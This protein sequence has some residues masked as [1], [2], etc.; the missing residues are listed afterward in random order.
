MCGVPTSLCE[1]KKFSLHQT[2]S[3]HD[4]DIHEHIHNNNIK[5]INNNKKTGYTKRVKGEVWSSPPLCILR[6]QHF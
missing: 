3:L 1:G 4:N 5:K 6:K 2:C